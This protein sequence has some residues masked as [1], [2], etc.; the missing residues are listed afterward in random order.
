MN[1]N[2]I[3]KINKTINID[4]DLSFKLWT[5]PE[6]LIKWWGPK[7]VTCTEANVNL[8]IGGKHKLVNELDTGE[9]IEIFGEYLKIEP[10]R[11]LQFSWN[12]ANISDNEVVTVRFIDKLDKTEIV[13][14]HEGIT[15]D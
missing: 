15:D 2:L 3:L 11:L 8:T 5:N 14:V 7:N 13:V 10:P 6:H 4:R 1:N 12:V 9:I